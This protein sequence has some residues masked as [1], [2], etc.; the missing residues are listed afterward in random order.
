VL[1]DADLQDPPEVIGEMLARWRDGYDVAYGVRTDRPGESPFKRATAKFF[2]RILRRLSDTE[3]PRDV[4]DFRLMDRR[5]VEA[6]RTMPER[7]RFIRG[8]VS[9]VGYRQIA[10]PYRREARF[11]GETKYPLFKMLGFAADG[12]TSFSLVP[13]RLASLA[14]FVTSGLAMLGV[15]YALAVRLLTRE[16]VPG[17]ATVFVAALFLGGIQLIALGIIGEYIGRIFVE[18]KRRPLYFVDERLGFGAEAGPPAAAF[19]RRL[20]AE[21][22]DRRAAHPSATVPT[23]RP[24]R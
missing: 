22:S 16:W 3:I 4:G 5:V 21:P 8:M 6:L 9:W 20:V 11:A 17:W 19:E 12:V 13:L 10:V 7:A 1:I 15:V 14:G 18:A 24:E 2:Y 23:R